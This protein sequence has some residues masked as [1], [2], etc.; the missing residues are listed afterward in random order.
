MIS[1]Q[2]LGLAGLLAF[3]AIIAAYTFGNNNI[4]FSLMY[5]IGAVTLALAIWRGPARLHFVVLALASGYRAYLQTAGGAALGVYPTWL[6]PIGFAYLA[7]WPTMMP[8][9]GIASVAV[10]RTWFIL[11]Y[12]MIGPLWVIVAANVLGAAGAWLWAAAEEAEGSA[13]LNDAPR[14]APP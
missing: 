9:L 3:E 10:S 14:I 2:K 13:T 6:V 8:K 11:W 1:R 5:A 7:I 12:W 4:T